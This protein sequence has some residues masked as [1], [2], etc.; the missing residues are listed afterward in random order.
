VT[1]AKRCDVPACEFPVFYLVSCVSREFQVRLI[2]SCFGHIGQ[3]VTA[4][5]EEHNP[6]MLNV[7]TI[8]VDW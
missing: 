4:E 8:G 6:G 1:T 3:V 7:T 5:L 2:G